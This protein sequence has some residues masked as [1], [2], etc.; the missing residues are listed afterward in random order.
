MTSPRPVRPLPPL[1][2]ITD[3]AAS[4]LP[5]HAEVVLSLLAGGARLIQVRDKRPSDRARVADLSAALVA[6]RPAGAVLI[7]NDRVDLAI[8]TGADGVH[9]GEEDLPAGVARRLLG[10]NRLVGIS[11]HSVDAAVA[12]AALPVDYVALGPIYTS[13]TKVTARTPLGPEAIAAVKARTETAIVAIGGITLERLA[14][15][16][17]AGADSVAVIA[18]LYTGPDIAARVRQYVHALTEGGAR[19]S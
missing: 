11:T 15:V 5:T 6:A 14:E 9:L 10:P 16:R 7:V 12:A 17:G 1:Y 3:L 19:R 8:I 18:D 13:A 2:A 4:S